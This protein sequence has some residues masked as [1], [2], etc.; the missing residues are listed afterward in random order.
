[1]ILKDHQKSAEYSLQTVLGFCF[2][3]YISDLFLAFSSVPLPSKLSHSEVNYG[4]LTS[5]R[6]RQDGAD[7]HNDQA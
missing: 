1:M 3:P 6:S 5:N 7:L 4:E 2:R